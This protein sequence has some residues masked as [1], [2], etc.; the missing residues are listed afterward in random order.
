MFAGFEHH[1]LRGPLD[2]FI[3][4]SE[5]DVVAASFDEDGGEFH[6]EDGLQE[7]HVVV[8][9]LFLQADGVC[10]DDDAAFALFGVIV[11]IAELFF[12][13]VGGGFALSGEDGWNEVGKALADSGTGFGDEVFSGCD[14]LFDGLCHGQLF[15]AGFVARQSARDGACGSQYAG[16]VVHWFGHAGFRGVLREGVTPLL[17]AEV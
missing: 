4:S 8:N 16:D 1:F 17:C 13:F 9:Q 12:V 14:G 15:G 7:G 10:G 6:G 2:G 11:V 5:A 3:E